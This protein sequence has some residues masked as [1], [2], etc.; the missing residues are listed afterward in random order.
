MFFP[1]DDCVWFV[2]SLAV[3]HHVYIVK[4]V[5]IEGSRDVRANVTE[6]VVEVALDAIDEIGKEPTIPIR[7]VEGISVT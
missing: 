1:R 4:V 5:N 7:C 6:Q 3:I 2:V